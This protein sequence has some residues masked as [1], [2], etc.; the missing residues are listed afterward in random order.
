MLKAHESEIALVVAVNENGAV[1]PPC[2]RCRE[3]MWQLNEVNADA[4]VVL[5][6]FN[7]VCLRKLLPF[8]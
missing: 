1:L 4:L 2:G 7:A 3:M 6:P 5:G 8:R